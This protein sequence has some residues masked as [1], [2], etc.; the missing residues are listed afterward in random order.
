MF[1][2][3][4][5]KEDDEPLI[6]LKTAQRLVVEEPEAE[7]LPEV[8][9]WQYW[10]L[11]WANRIPYKITF[12]LQSIGV[13]GLFAVGG[14]LTLDF[15]F[16]SAYAAAGIEPTATLTPL[17]PLPTR[18]SIPTATP[19]ITPTPTPIPQGKGKAMADIFTSAYAGFD[20]RFST[21]LMGSSPDYEEYLLCFD[22][23]GI[24]R[25]GFGNVAEETWGATPFCMPGVFDSISRASNILITSDVLHSIGLTEVEWIGIS[26]HIYEHGAP[27]DYAI[28]CPAG[29]VAQT[30][31]YCLGSR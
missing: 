26:V 24:R 9:M 14:V 29:V 4:K 20:N 31:K 22:G 3:K 2:R 27:D 28:F 12:A 19:S 10:R 16:G 21:N 17:P 7:P 18:T 1:N 6:Q 30:S 11:K 13:V 15:M 8:S 25:D 5:T 23:T